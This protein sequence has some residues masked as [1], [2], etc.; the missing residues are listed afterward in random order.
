MCKPSSRTFY[1]HST[2]HSKWNAS[3]LPPYFGIEYSVGE[4]QSHP[5]IGPEPIV[6][7]SLGQTTDIIVKGT[8]GD[9]VT[10]CGTSVTPCKKI[11]SQ[12]YKR[13]LTIRIDK[14]GVLFR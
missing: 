5:V 10:G 8:I 4:E 13:I 11:D 9:L 2:I 1:I 12:I 3:A 14:V 7:K 6:Q